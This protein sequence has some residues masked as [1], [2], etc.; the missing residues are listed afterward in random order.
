M[1]IIETLAKEFSLLKSG[2]SDFHGD[3]KPDIQLGIGKGDLLVPASYYYELKK[4]KMNI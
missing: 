4:F 1:N 2:G 3:N